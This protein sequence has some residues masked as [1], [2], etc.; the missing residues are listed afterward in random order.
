MFSVQSS[1]LKNIVNFKGGVMLSYVCII[2]WFFI[3]M[4]YFEG[5]C[6]CGGLNLVVFY[7][8]QS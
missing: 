2:W 4:R 6:E 5:G 3:V 7:M 8:L 1:H